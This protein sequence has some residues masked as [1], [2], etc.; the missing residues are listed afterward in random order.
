MV[1]IPDH[2][3]IPMGLYGQVFTIMVFAL[4]QD[5]ALTTILPCLNLVLIFSGEIVMA[6][7]EEKIYKSTCLMCHGVCG[8]LVHVR[9]GKVVKIT[10]DK[11][12]P[13]S[14][15]YIYHPERLRHPLKRVGERLSEN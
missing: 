2:I 4:A 14:N 9:D 8:V 3:L 7:E 13:S 11:S 10:G 6:K 5:F 15:G 12:R 1:A